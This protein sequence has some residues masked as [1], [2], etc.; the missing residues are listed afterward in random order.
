MAKSDKKRNTVLIPSSKTSLLSIIVLTLLGGCTPDAGPD[1]AD[2][3]QKADLVLQDGAIYTMDPDRSWQEAVAIFDGRIIYVGC[4]LG[5]AAFVG[6][7]TRVVNLKGNMVLPGLQ[8]L[9][10]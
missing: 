6:P 7:D 8:D 2:Q 4:N 5:V 3:A 9:A 10:K 1:Q